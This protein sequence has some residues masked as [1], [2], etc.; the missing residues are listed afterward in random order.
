VAQSGNDVS[1]W[2]LFGFD[3][4]RLAGS[5]V[6]GLR[7]LLWGSESGLQRRFMPQACLTGDVQWIEE[8]DAKVFGLSTYPSAVAG[9]TAVL[10]PDDLVLTRRIELPSVAE[11]EL[12]AM[13]MFEAEVNSPFSKEDTS[14]GWR[15]LSREASQLILILAIASRRAIDLHLDAS[16]A[17]SRS[18]LGDVEVWAN[19]EGQLVQFLGFGEALR[20]TEYIATLSRYVAKMVLLALAVAALVWWPAGALSI[21][22]GQLKEMLVETELRAGTATAARNSLIDMED[23]LTAAFEFYSE[24]LLYDRWLDE[25]A[26]LTPDS[27][28]LTAMS[29]NK[30]R[31][32]FS[33]QAGNAAALQTTLASVDILNEVTA[34]SAFT[35]DNRTGKERFTLTMRLVTAQQ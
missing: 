4:E 10:L 32:T 13:A 15:V 25:V 33:G 14:F 2:S 9:A 21:K 28:Y 16:L 24:R 5:V 23:R 30:D 17:D 6:L 1:Q 12:A 18:D 7:Q 22:E 29:F 26:T 35:R 31:L 34:P 19:H 3:L 11:A 8:K 27:A 20:K